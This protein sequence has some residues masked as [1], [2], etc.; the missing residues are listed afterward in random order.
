MDKQAPVVTWE[1]SLET[2]LS[3][4][5]IQPLRSRDDPKGRQN[6]SVGMAVTYKKSRNGSARNYLRRPSFWTT[7]L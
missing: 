7:V 6:N 4:V 2:H 1:I 5:L 3:A